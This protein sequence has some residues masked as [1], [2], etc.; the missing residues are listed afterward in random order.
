MLF[1]IYRAYLEG[2]ARIRAF[3]IG[4][5]NHEN[6]RYGHSQPQKARPMGRTP[7][8]DQSHRTRLSSRP[9]S[10]RRR[11]LRRSPRRRRTLRQR[12]GQVHL[13]S[14][15]QLER[16]AASSPTFSM[17]PAPAITTG[18]P[19]ST[20]WPSTLFQTTTGT[21]FPQPRPSANSPSAPAPA[22]N[23]T[24]GSPTAKPG[25]SSKTAPPPRS[26]SAA[27]STST[28]LSKTTSHR[29]E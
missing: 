28:A 13:R 27:A 2:A 7:F 17:Q 24:S 16:P 22:T 25:I 14:R 8:Y 5:N 21:S 9:A 26:Q 15:N 10:R 4:R 3:S 1:W 23:K 19:T 20:I 29:P 12:P 6:F 18:N 11:T